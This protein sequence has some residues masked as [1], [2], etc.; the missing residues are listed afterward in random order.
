MK[1]LFLTM[2]AAL[3]F[4]H[5]ARAEEG[6]TCAAIK[7][8]RVVQKG[9]AGKKAES[10]IR[11]LRFDELCGKDQHSLPLERDQE[12]EISLDKESVV[13]RLL[14]AG[15]SELARKRAKL[16]DQ[17]LELKYKPR[18]AGEL[19]VDVNCKP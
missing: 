5:E 17:K 12:L 10:F 4:I 6:K 13:A 15:G 7:Q 9:K 1:Y 16:T 2:L 3:P 19:A 11:R 8:C 14:G 18:Q